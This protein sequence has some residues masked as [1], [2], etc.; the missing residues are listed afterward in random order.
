MSQISFWVAKEVCAAPNLKHRIA[1]LKYFLHMA[2]ICLEQ[3]NYNTWHESL[4]AS[5][6]W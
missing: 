4:A 3:R 1:V 5:F 6:P 2:T